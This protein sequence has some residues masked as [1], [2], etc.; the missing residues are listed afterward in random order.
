MNKE[1]ISV[2]SASEIVFS[3]TLA[4]PTEQ[5]ELAESAGRYLAEPMT[6]LLDQ[7]QF[8]KSAMDGFAYKSEGKMAET[9]QTLQI[10]QN[11]VARAGT[12]GLPEVKQGEAI[13]IMTGAPVPPGCDAVCR[14]EFTEVHGFQLTI[15][16]EEHSPNII[17]KG[18]SQQ[19]GT[20]LA[21]AGLITPEKAAIIASSGYGAVKVFK[22]P[23]VGIIS[24]GDELLTPGEPYKPGAIYDTNSYFLS[25]KL[26]ALGAEVTFYGHFPDSKE[27]LAEAYSAALEHS[28]VIIFFGGVSMGRFDFTRDI[29][30]S[31]G[32]KVLVHGVHLKPGKPFLFACSRD[33]FVF[34]MPGNPV[35]T[36]AVTE[37]FV[38]PFLLSSLDKSYRGPKKLKVV[39]SENFQRKHDRRF[40]LRP[41]TLSQ[42]GARL[43]YVP[44]KPYTGSS[45]LSSLG[46]ADAFIEVPAGEPGIN[47]GDI[48]D[49]RP[50]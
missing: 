38:R 34:G 14:I 30:E 7:P 45:M 23:R 4:L 12:F 1:I 42:E 41:V 29:I 20:L 19:A 17:A 16:Q 44:V 50:F 3:K 47:K 24:T 43:T 36:A 15:T 5:V 6:A 37:L 48:I 31:S 49:A 21:S 39:A 18:S 33:K 32:A 9:G 2:Q 27:Q 35:S 11:V 8:D 26:R 40:E 46:Q 28:D 22:K 10:L 13:A 25:P